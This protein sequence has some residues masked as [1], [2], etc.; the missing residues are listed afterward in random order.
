MTSVDIFPSQLAFLSRKNYNT[1]TDNLL[2]HS[3]TDNVYICLQ[4][5]TDA[6]KLLLHVLSLCLPASYRRV[7][8]DRTE[9]L[10]TSQQVSFFWKW[11]SSNFYL[12][13]ESCFAPVCT[14]L[15]DLP[16]VHCS[17]KYDQVIS[18]CRV[19]YEGNEYNTLQSHIT[20]L[21]HDLCTGVWVART[22]DWVLTAVG[23]GLDHCGHWP[24]Q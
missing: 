10:K 17:E 3:E 22:A 16:I 6:P 5:F 18:L 24:V 8:P 7:T 1:F 2:K 11:W 15:D 20:C 13:E 14:G 4:I 12:W 21:F 19:V 9:G 23:W